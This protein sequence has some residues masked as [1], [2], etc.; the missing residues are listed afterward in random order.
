MADVGIVG[1]PAG[2]GRD[3]LFQFLSQFRP[4]AFYLPIAF[5]KVD[6]N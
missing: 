5:L 3:G 1:R 6:F 2:P 4:Q